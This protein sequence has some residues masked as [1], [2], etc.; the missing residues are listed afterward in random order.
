M[1]LI[2]GLDTARRVAVVIPLDDSFP[3]RAQAAG[4]LFNALTGVAPRPDR[5]A[6]AQ[7]RD[8][9]TGC[10]IVLATLAMAVAIIGTT[11]VAGMTPRFVWNASASVRW[12]SG[13]R[14]MTSASSTCGRTIRARAILPSPLFR[15]TRPVS[16]R[17]RLLYNLSGVQ[18]GPFSL[19]SGAVSFIS[20]CGPLLPSPTCGQHG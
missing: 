3:V 14:H 2:G 6:A 5:L 12:R 20:E 1:A 19:G 9:M 17:E 16:R 4:C 11:M 7:A 18:G 15:R 10:V 8:A 13:W